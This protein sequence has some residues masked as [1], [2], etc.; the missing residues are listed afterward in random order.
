MSVSTPDTSIRLDVDAPKKDAVVAT[1]DPATSP[2]EVGVWV[3]SAITNPGSLNQS[4]IGTFEVLVRYLLNNLSSITS[5][6][7]TVL[8]V[9]LGG[10]NA[11]VI[12]GGVVGTGDLVLE[13]G[14]PLVD[15]GNSH[16]ID[17]TWK[18]LRERWQEEN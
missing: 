8:R 18:R 11:D 17:R 9:P 4:I 15:T 7:P 2:N 13:V 10:T 6:A 14:Q 1:G 3:G 12:V 16:L 5:T